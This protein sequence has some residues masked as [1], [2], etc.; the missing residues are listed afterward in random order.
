MKYL[1]HQIFYDKKSQSSLD[2]GF[3]PLNNVEN[4]RP[5]WYELWVIKNFLENT[6]LISDAWYGFLSPRFYGKIRLTAKDIYE[7]LQTVDPSADVVT[8]SYSWEQIAYFLNPFEQGELF[9]PG[10][11]KISQQFFDLIDPGEV[12]ISKLVGHS[13]NSVFC[14]FSWVNPRLCRG[15][16]NV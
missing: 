14:N 13:G 8:I 5:D 10:L 6:D 2:P 9:H 11:T 1:V 16:I 7:F 12:N 4:Q 3:I 15:T